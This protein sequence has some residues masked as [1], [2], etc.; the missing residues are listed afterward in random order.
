MNYTL[1]M[2]I[3]D[4]KNPLWGVNIVYLISPTTENIDL[5]VHHCRNSYFDNIYINFTSPADQTLLKDFATK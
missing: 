1:H 3:S 4:V 5:I 2:K